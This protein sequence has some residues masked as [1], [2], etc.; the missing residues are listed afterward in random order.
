MKALVG[1]PPLRARQVETLRAARRPAIHHGVRHSGWNCRPKAA[2]PP[3]TCTGNVASAEHRRAAGSH[4]DAI[5]RHGRARA[6]RPLGQVE[7]DLRADGIIADL[8]RP[9]GW[10]DTPRRTIICASEAE[11]DALALGQRNADPVDFTADEIVAAV[12]S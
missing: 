1:W 8:A 11:A 3:D 10:P 9:A 4:C 5:G 2:P 6:R 7:P 12:G